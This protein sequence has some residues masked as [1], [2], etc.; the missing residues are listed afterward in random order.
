VVDD[1][2]GRPSISRDD[3]RHLISER[4]EAEARHREVAERQAVE[5]ERQWVAGLRGGVSAAEVPDGLHPA[6]ATLAAAQDAM[7][8]A[9]GARGGIEQ[10]RRACGAGRTLA[11]RG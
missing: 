7:P 8:P 5:L 2:L 6:A 3:A 1:D 11:F 10:P 9:D 4:Q